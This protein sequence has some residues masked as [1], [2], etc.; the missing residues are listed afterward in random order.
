METSRLEVVVAKITVGLCFGVV[1]DRYFRGDVN[2]EMNRMLSSKSQAP[3][4]G[5]FRSP[6]GSYFPQNDELDWTRG[7]A[8]ISPGAIP[9]E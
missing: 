5:L 4:G 1:S 3:R 2:C 6:F 7:P 9:A 8:A